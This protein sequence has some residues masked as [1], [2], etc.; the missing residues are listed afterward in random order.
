MS[1][2][3]LSGVTAAQSQQVNSAT[4][5]PAPSSS[6]PT[7][8]SLPLFSTGGKKG[9]ASQISGHQ[10]PPFYPTPHFLRETKP[11]EPTLFS[12][13]MSVAS[14][15]AI[16]PVPSRLLPGGIVGDPIAIEYKTDSIK[17]AESANALMKTL[18]L[19]QPAPHFIQ[20]LSD[21]VAK[22]QEKMSEGNGK[23]NLGGY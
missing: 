21:N 19:P 20:P 10:H 4:D 1:V 8:H 15:G 17:G 5:L 3:L 7:S 18:K 16:H 23:P 22:T 6:L 2:A 11:S 12:A 13:P 14:K 9:Y